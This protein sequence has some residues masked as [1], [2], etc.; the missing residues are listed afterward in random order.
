MSFAKQGETM[1]QTNPGV[2]SR[3]R[4][5]FLASGSALMAATIV[6]PH[7]LGGPQHVAPSDRV[8]VALVGAGGRG[9]QNAR[10]LLKLSDVRITAVADPAELWDLSDFYYRGTA[11]RHPVCAE[12]E[13]HYATTESG[14]KCQ[15][16]EDYR[17][18]LEQRAGDIDAILC[19]TPDHQHAHASLAAI[20]AGKHVYCEKP[21][22]HNIAEARLVSSAAEKAGVATQ[23]GNQGHSRDTIRETCELIRAGA[24]G[25]VHEV[26]AWVPATRW[27]PTLDKAPTAAQKLPQGLNWDLW[28]G[29]RQ[30]P[31]FNH[32]YAPV[33]WRDFWAFGCGAMGDFGCHDLDSA[34]WALDL[35]L[36]TR[37]EMRAAGSTDPAMAP[38]GEIGYFDFDARGSSPAVRIHWYSGGLRPPTPDALPESVK[39]PS[40]G[41]LFVGSKGVM[42]CGGAGGKATIYPESY[43]ETVVP[44]EPSLVR[45]SG[46]HRDWV[47]AIKG[48]PPASSEFRYGAKLTEI[49]LL[50]LVAL[51]TGEVI[52]WDPQTMKAKGCPEADAIIQGQ[53]RKGW[54][55][56]A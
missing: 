36:P 51:R 15:Q 22:T 56:D 44:P 54:S 52:Y 3:S 31:E 14:F 33:S 26:H 48:G 37:I 29:V 45:S 20:R 18:L 28:C 1:P 19:A 9:R 47:D 34:V 23:L 7:V 11:G 6:Q 41:V 30:P 53:Y 25:S 32:A 55:L 39:L 43:A 50:G 35:G 24:I 13:Q 49:T 2:G 12:I 40:R 46:H 17:Q 38:F 27:N 16:F 5:D 10:E 8:N 42:V 21:L 4:R